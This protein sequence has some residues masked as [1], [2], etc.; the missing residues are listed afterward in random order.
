[1]PGILQGRAAY[2][3]RQ[4]ELKKSASASAK[5]SGALQGG[6]SGN[7]IAVTIAR[8][9]LTTQQYLS[10]YIP[11]YLCLRDEK[12]VRAYF[13]KIVEAGIAAIDTE[14]TGLDPWTCHVVGLCSYVKGEKPCYIPVGHVG[15]VTGQLLPGQVSEDFL[16][17]Q[18]ERCKDVKWI[19]HNAKFDI[20][21]IKHSF[22]IQLPAYWDTMVAATLLN[23]NE[24]HGLKQLHLKY[25]DSQDEKALTISTLFDGLN[26][27]LIPIE[28]AYLYAAGDA[29]KTYELYEFQKKFLDTEALKGPRWIMDNIEMPVI[30]VI[31]DMEEAGINVDMEYCKM[32]HEKYTRKLQ[33]A[34]AACYQCLAKY[35]DAIDL[36]KRTTPNHKLSNPISLGSPTQIAILL[37]DILKLTP[38]G[39][40]NFGRATGEQVLLLI[41][42]EFPK[43]LLEYRAMQKL[44]S[45][46][47]DKLPNEVNPK[48]GHIHPQFNAMGAATGRMSS[49][50]PNLQNIPS[51]NKDIRQMFT[52]SEGYYLVSGDYSLL[53]MLAVVKLS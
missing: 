11:Q 26:F 28:C 6:R 27:A 13:D 4:A 31:I 51:H 43:L 50:N 49:N 24:P 21:F 5:K 45:T 46:Y 2:A 29:I 19:Y 41:D 8:I 37:Y 47:V 32:L 16:R 1:M 38:K 3:K 7:N 35:Q 9:K 10:K 34:E 25:C 20:K 30:P 23:E 44:I 18:L 17:S 40:K 48:T 53:N 12:A 22:G 52:A 39:H 42:H 36:Y 15:N 33:E 14:T